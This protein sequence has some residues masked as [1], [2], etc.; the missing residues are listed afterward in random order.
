MRYFLSKQ[1]TGRY[2]VFS[3]F[4][5]TCSTLLSWS[6]DYRFDATSVPESVCVCMCVRQAE[7]SVFMCR[8][9][10]RAVVPHRPRAPPSRRDLSLSRTYPASA[11]T[12]S[13][14]ALTGSMRAAVSVT[15]ENA[16][17]ISYSLMQL[18]RSDTAVGNAPFSATPAAPTPAPAPAPTPAAGVNLQAVVEVLTS[19]LT[20]TQSVPTKVAILKWFRHLEEQLPDAVSSH[21]PCR[22]VPCRDLSCRVVM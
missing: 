15:K 20:E 9:P 21:G 17:T 10:H 2:R 18:V 8:V 22:A 5:V 7:F 19:R 13:V 16:K 14:L 12:R 4:F 3:C 11:V 6:H 1:Q